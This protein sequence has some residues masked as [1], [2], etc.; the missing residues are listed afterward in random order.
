[1]NPVAKALI[2]AGAVLIVA[3][4]IWQFGGKY[5]P[6]GRLPGDIRYESGNVR[7]YFPIVTCLLISVIGSLILY[8]IRLMK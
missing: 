7:F 1:M 5:I 8:L 2:I 6:L 3:G 4:L